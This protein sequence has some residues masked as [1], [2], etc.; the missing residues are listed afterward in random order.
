[1]AG[2]YI[3]DQAV[4]GVYLGD[5]PV[6]GVYL[7]DTLIWPTTTPPLYAVTFDGPN[8]SGLPGF[9]ADLNV[10][11]VAS[12]RAQIAALG[13]GSGRVDA[14][15]TYQDGPNAG[16]TDTDD[17]IITAQFIAPTGAQA[18]NNHTSLILRSNDTFN[19][20]TKVTAEFSTSGCRII[21]HSGATP[22]QRATGA[23]IPNT[24]LVRVEA[25]GNAYRCYLDTA[26]VPFMSWTDT[27]N[28]VQRGPAQRR[29]GVAVSGNYPIFQQMFRSFGIDWIEVRNG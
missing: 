2:L 7:G 15:L 9:R 23:G 28:V 19:A 14:W 10:A 27:L 12:G 17:Q 11:E 8:Q 29:W 1:M 5:Q 6:A 16:R 13:M 25:I 3:G 26:T 24:S 20:G 21:S 18:S 4:A 22:T